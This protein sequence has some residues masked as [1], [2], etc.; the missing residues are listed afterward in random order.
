MII[1]KELLFLANEAS[2]VGADKNISLL[3]RA[4]GLPH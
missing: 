3:S 2:V 4:S 1:K